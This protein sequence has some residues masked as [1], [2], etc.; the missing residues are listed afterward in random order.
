[1]SMDQ[2]INVLVTITLIEMMVAIGLGVT[3]A[4]LANVARDWRLVARAGLANYVLVPA[5]TL[6]L[7]V[8]IAPH[9]MVAAGF[10]ILAVC[11]GAP[12]GPPF[13]AIAR[14]NV[15]VAVG[16][17]VL[18][19]GSSALL[20]PALMGVL[21]PLVAGD[22]PLQIDA[23]K[24]ATTLLATQLAPLL[25]GVALRQWRPA[26]ANRL[27]KPADWLSKLLN[28]AT[29]GLI[30]V[31]QFHLLFDIR[32][33]GLVGMVVLLIASWGAGWW[34]GGNQPD[35]R[36][37]MTLTASLRNA[38]VGLVIASGSF[39]GTSAVTAVL[40]YGLVEL[41]G[42]LVLAIVWGRHS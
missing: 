32:F 29:I 19:A 7:L 4:D 28:L 41:F 25:V 26:W 5:A 34:L 27:R 20:A 42:S 14:G 10:L 36:R 18:L 37:A 23:V 31:A 11:P 40:V 21:T 8:L 13:T 1:M 30:L 2:V 22:D 3:F 24:I 16:L 15:P 39:P 17:M 33:T 12:F 9:P 6:G 35:V 38:G